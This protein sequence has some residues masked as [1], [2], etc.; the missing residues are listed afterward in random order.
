MNNDSLEYVKK[1]DKCQRYYNIPRAPPN[2][3][4]QITIPWPFAIWGTDLI[5]S[6]PTVNGV[7]YMIVAVDHFR[8]WIEAEAFH[9][10]RD[11]EVKNITWKNVI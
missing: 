8:K 6:L 1:C 11:R 4:T 9:H 3:L 7:K 5:G 10:V 2:K